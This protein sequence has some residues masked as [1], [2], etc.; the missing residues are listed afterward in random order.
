MTASDDLLAPLRDVDDDVRALAA[1]PLIEKGRRQRRNR[2]LTAA[3]G[4]VAMVVAAAWI[5]VGPLPGQ[6]DTVLAAPGAAQGPG[7]I[8]R[9]GTAVLA[10]GTAAIDMTVELP[11]VLSRVEPSTA[12][13]LPRRSVSA[14]GAVDFTR[15]TS[16]MKVTT[17]LDGRSVSIQL[18]ATPKQSYV[19]HLLKPNKWVA[20]PSINEI[21]GVAGADAPLDPQSILDQLPVDATNVTYVGGETLRGTPTSHYRGTFSP[22]PA[23]RL[24]FD[25]WLDGA[26]LPRRVTVT[27]RV[28]TETVSVKLEMHSFGDA[29]TIRTPNASDLIS[30]EEAA[31]DLKSLLP[32]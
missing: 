9:V 7:L 24:P 2:R 12:A 18:L 31:E 6:G 13:P 3:G 1:T 30:R 17:K 10:E 4:S 21:F 14:T 29:V 32:K 16:T 5:G 19:S 15:Q 26:G 22:D 8:K 28:E 25:I 23:V 11:D 27:Q 20:V